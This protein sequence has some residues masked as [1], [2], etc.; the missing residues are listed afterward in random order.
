[1]EDILECLNSTELARRKFREIA[2]IAG[3]VFQGYPG[4]SKSTR[5]VQASSGL[6]YDMFARYEPDNRLLDQARGLSFDVSRADADF[7]R[8][9]GQGRRAKTKRQREGRRSCKYRAHW[10]GLPKSDGAQKRETIKREAP[11]GRFAVTASIWVPEQPV[12]LAQFA[13][14]TTARKSDVIRN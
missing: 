12:R 1:M 9:L 2:R 5:Q 13:R 8:R 7:A 11:Q 4:S 10:Q 3:L 14:P 6:F